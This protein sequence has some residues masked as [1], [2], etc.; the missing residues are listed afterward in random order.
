MARDWLKQEHPLFKQRREEWL[1]NE[2]RLQ[3]G[4]DILSE[5]APFEYED[6]PPDNA[7]PAAITELGQYEARQRQAT[8]LNFPAMYADDMIGNLMRQAPKPGA[9][10]SFGS[11]GEVRPEA[12]GQPTRAELVFHNVDGVGIDGSQWDNWWGDVMA[13]AMATGHRWIFC[14]ATESAPLTEQDEIDGLR[15]FLVDFSPASVPMWH[16]DKGTLHYAI[17][18]VNKPRPK[19]VK[20]KIEGIDGP[21]QVA[22]LLL[23]R[24]GFKGLDGGEDGDVYSGGG[25]WLYDK[26]GDLFDPDT[27]DVNEDGSPK[28]DGAGKP[29]RVPGSRGTWDKTSGR[30]PM[31]PFYYQRDKGTAEHPNMSVPG[32]WGLGQLA[33]S[34]MNLSS[35][36]D[37]DAWDA[38]ASLLFLLGVDKKGWDLAT[39]KIENGSKMIPLP[40]SRDGIV[41]AIHDGAMGAVTAEVFTTRLRA[42]LDELKQTAAL[43]Q[44]STP[45]ASGTSKEAGHAEARG[46]RLASMASEVEDGQRQ[47]IHLLELRFGAA[48]EPSGAVAW[49]RKFVLSNLSDD[50]QRVINLEVSAGISSPTLDAELILQAVRGSPT[51]TALPEAVLTAAETELK[52]A[53]QNKADQA[54][55]MKALTDEMAAGGFGGGAGGSEDPAPNGKPPK[56]EP[57]GA[58]AEA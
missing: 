48:T 33:V 11:L 43:G 49:P 14:D 28:L 46:P 19:L 16:L 39:E 9:G 45:D 24:K 38:A 7:E 41:P 26:D 15:P 42:K 5:L 21:E 22:R 6:I 52:Q 27:P 20:D 8:Y 35:A 17:V 55:R 51:L 3:G 13:K 58:G 57:A 47:A 34:Y 31:F 10:L 50:I 40:P 2:R 29:A 23:V 18:L 32:L 25:W 44:Q 36:A 56:K 1:R 30:I 53:A 37:F 54:E 4:E 12:T